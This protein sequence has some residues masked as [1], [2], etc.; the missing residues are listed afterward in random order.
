MGSQPVR[1]VEQPDDS[2][3]VGAEW[4]TDTTC[5]ERPPMGAILHALEIPPIGGDTLFANQSLAFETLS[6]GMQRMLSGLNAVHN[7]NWK[8]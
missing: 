4:H 7:E 1:L 3:T 2:R 8:N 6:A 5:W